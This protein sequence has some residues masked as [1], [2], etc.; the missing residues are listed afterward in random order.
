MIY[1]VTVGRY[2]LSLLDEVEIH[3]SVDL[4]ADTAV[5]RLPG[6]VY[7]RAMNIEDRIA[8]G[9]KVLIQR[10]VNIV[11]NYSLENTP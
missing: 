9:D 7:N 1:R 2:R 4:L 5:I 6:A 8:R 11:A 10:A 3:K